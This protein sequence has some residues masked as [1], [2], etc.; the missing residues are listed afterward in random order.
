MPQNIC[1]WFVKCVLLMLLI[2]FTSFWWAGV[3]SECF[4]SFKSA[5]HFTTQLIQF[6]KFL[7][8]LKRKCTDITSCQN[9]PNQLDCG[10]RACCSN[11]NQ[12]QL[13]LKVVELDIVF[14]TTYQR[15]SGAW[16]WC[17]Q[18]SCF[19]TLCLISTPENDNDYNLVHRINV[20]LSSPNSSIVFV[21]VYLK[22]TSY[23]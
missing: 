19:Q 7:P 4:V 11:T 12:N 21:S 1:S 2:A 22:T 14:L 13:K 17:S 20:I 5:N 16:Y 8:S 18:E 9:T 23:A 3:T 15:S 10:K 6:Q